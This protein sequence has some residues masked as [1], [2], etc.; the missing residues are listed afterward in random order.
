[1]LYWLCILCVYY[2]FIYTVLIL[3][4]HIYTIAVLIT[5][6]VPYISSFVNIFVHSCH[7]LGNIKSVLVG[8]HLYILLGILYLLGLSRR[9]RNLRRVVFFIY[10][11]IFFFI[12][13]LPYCYRV[14]PISLSCRPNFLIWYKERV[15]PPICV[16][17]PGFA[18]FYS[19]FLAFYHQTDRK[20]FILCISYRLGTE[21][22]FRN[23][24][25][26]VCFEC[27]FPCFYFLLFFF[28]IIK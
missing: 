7:V 1:M 9:V 3:R 11:F 2:I 24:I 17:F 8:I 18:A 12:F 14:G 23:I 13:T 21:Q 4:L 27:V 20:Y 19:E 5:W 26:L 28:E 16:L 10:L 22:T 15:T 6:F 25:L